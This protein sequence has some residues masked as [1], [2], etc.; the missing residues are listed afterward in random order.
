MSL[1]KEVNVYTNGEPE[2]LSTFSNV[3]YF[4][5]Q[6]LRKLNIKV[7][8]INIEPNAVW[9]KNWNRF[10][11]RLI[12]L[13][14]PNSMFAYDRTTLNDWDTRRKIRKAVKEYPN[15]QAEI[16]LTFIANAKGISKAP[17][18]LLSDWNYEYV[19]EHFWEKK[20]DFFQKRAIRRQDK[21][22]NDSDHIF[23]LFPG[24]MRIMQEKYKNPQIHYLGNFVNCL[25]EPKKSQESIEKKKQS[26]DL[27]F[28]GKNHYKEG[29]LTLLEAFKSIREK[30]PDWVLHIIGMQAKDFDS[31][32]EQVIC[33]GYLDKEKEEEKLK[34][35]E[36]LE[37]S[38]LFINTSPK[39]GAF[40]ATLE[41]LY[42]YNPIVVSPYDEFLEN[43]GEKPNFGL[44][45]SQNDPETLKKT[46]LD[47][48]ESDQYEKLCQNAHEAVKDFTWDRVS[49]RVIQE[50]GFQIE[51]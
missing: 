47:I 46:I 31:L 45:C 25:L 27:L 20:P 48:L 8:P 50:I 22:M 16:F 33:Y 11:L 15:S 44:Y 32:P 21:L 9:G 42:F 36:L 18:V 23:F 51:K 38:K 24:S 43:F 2:K 34:F 3:P 28:I 30:Y 14:I 29:A 49:E 13:I 39:W 40:S 6:S 10:I 7:N 12:R 41:A 4:F 17:T 26:R 1:M 37:R 35:Y 5:I 19:I